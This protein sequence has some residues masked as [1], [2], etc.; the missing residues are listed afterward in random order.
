LWDPRSNEHTILLDYDG[1]VTDCAFSPDSTLL[2]ATTSD[3]AVH[4]WDMRNRAPLPALTGHNATATCCAFSPMGNEL[5][6]VDMTGAVLIWDLSTRTCK[7]GL[8]VATAIRHIAW[9]PTGNVLAVIGDA[10]PFRLAY[11]RSYVAPSQG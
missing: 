5:A 1:V 7:A 9:E 8:R 6:T 10:G 3:G 2:A 4:L 11:R